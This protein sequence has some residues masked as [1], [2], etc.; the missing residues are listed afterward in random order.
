MRG[1]LLS[2]AAAAVLVSM[3]AAPAAS[4]NSIQTAPL[5]VTGQGAAAA[6]GSRV[7]TVA[8]A[9][10]APATA[11]PAGAVPPAEGHH[12]PRRSGATDDAQCRRQCPDHQGPRV[13]RGRIVAGGAYRHPYR[14]ERCR[15]H[16]RDR[17]RFGFDPPSGDKSR[18]SRSERVVRG[19]S[20]PCHRRHS[21]P[22]PKYRGEELCVRT[23]FQS[24]ARRQ[25]ADELRRIP[26]RTVAVH[27][28][29]ARNAAVGDIAY[30][31]SAT[32]GRAGY[33]AKG[34]DRR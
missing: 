3:T 20:D 32:E 11:I 21:A 23:G 30:R 27:G 24:G 22:V 7:R 25:P 13:V 16:Q 19:P 18:P 9:A 28:E 1:F 34:P 14:R 31:R 17:D 33:L 29:Y 5:V 12:R 8:T 6:G 10:A 26:V 4:S 2:L 15:E